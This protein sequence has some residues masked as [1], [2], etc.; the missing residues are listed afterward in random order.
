MGE[1][2]A[3]A[4]LDVENKVGE[5]VASGATLEAS[6]SFGRF[7]RDSLSWEKWSSFSQN[8]YL[9]E[10]E[11]F[12]A[13]G[14]VAQKKAYF[15]AHYKKVAS[16]KA[17]PQGQEEKQSEI[18]AL[19][20]NDGN[21]E[22]ILHRNTSGTD[23]E[24]DIVMGQSSGEEVEQVS[25]SN[26]VLDSSLLD[27]SN[28]SATSTIECRNSLVDGAKEEFDS[29]PDSIE[30]S[31]LEEAVVVQEGTCINGSQETVK[32]LPAIVQE[33]TNLNGAQDMVQFRLVLEET[34]NKL[35]IEKD[36]A[37]L[38]SSII[39][40][41]IIPT[42]KER[43]L[44]RTK[45]KPA[46]PLPKKSPQIST[47]K[48]AKLTPSPTLM[49]ASSS[50]TKR[51][52]GLA[53]PRSKNLS[54]GERK[55]IVPPPLHM[56]ASLSPANSESTPPTMTRKSL[57]MEKMGDKDI[58][59]RAF[60]TFQNNFNQ[61]RSSSSSYEM[62][63]REKEVSTARPEQ[64]F[65]SSL[66]SRKENKGLRK[67]AEKVDAQKGQLGRSLNSPLARSLKGASMD[68]RIAKP[69]PSSIGSISDGRA[70]K[71]REFSNKL[72][73]KSYAKEV[74]IT[75]L[76]SKPKEG[77]LRQSLNSKAT[78]MPGSYMGH[79]IS[80]NLLDKY[81]DLIGTSLN[82]RSDTPRK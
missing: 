28:D 73:E 34:R 33:E 10:V 36:T 77:K 59:K 75:R 80:K 63:S 5:S 41:K 37:N 24:V 20:M 9:E 13:P 22:E 54:A 47:P 16:R 6:V 1:S 74:E 62:S 70:E 64:K 76:H 60:K 3:T 11:K 43:D 8:K 31:E 27:E 25:D 57:I 17:K 79:G 67:A 78:P 35:E 2:T 18:K 42:R 55:E 4:A 15:E 68:Q 61:V 49:S 45:K 32:L 71:Q 65:S 81:R 26:C 21:G 53:F 52:S 40:E 29:I 23:T 56:S 39:S 44:A 12:S 58:V 19:T 50:I 14:S 66:T 69:A 38:D 46:S 7:E 30:L 51:E 82:S 72:E 48:L